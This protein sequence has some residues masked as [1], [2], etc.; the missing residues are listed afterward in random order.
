MLTSQTSAAA[1]RSTNPSPADSGLALAL[2]KASPDCVKVL[3][4]D[5]NLQS[6]ND[7]GQALLEMDDPGLLHGH[8]WPELWREDGGERAT[9]A[10]AMA[11]DGG[12]DRFRGAADTLKGTSK[13]WDVRVSPIFGPDGRPSHILVVSSDITQE[14][15]NEARL[16]DVARRVTEN[17]RTETENLR[18]LL[19]NA[20]SIM[21]VLRGPDHVIELLN[22]AS[23]QLVSFR[24]LLG[25]SVR[26]AFDGPEGQ[27]IA[28]VL[29]GVYRSGEPFLAS[30]APVKL[31]RHKDA[32]P[33][34]AFL[35]LVFQPIRDDQGLITGVFIEGSDIT[36]R[37]RAEHSLAESER[38]LRLAQQVAGIGSLE[39]DVATG[40]VRGS[41]QFWRLWGLEPT[42]SAS[43]TTLEDIVIPEDRAIKSTAET[44][45]AGTATPKVEYRI[46]RPDTGE[47]RWLARHIEFI[48]APDGS[49]R[50]MIGVMQDITER[51]EAEEQR[52]LLTRELEHRMKNT[53]AMVGALATQTLKGNDMPAARTAFGARLAALSSANDILT[54]RSWTS[55]P[56]LEVVEGALAAHQAGED[57]LRLSGTMLRLSAKQALS[58]S[59]G[60]HELATNAAKYGALSNGTGTVDIGWDVVAA[61]P[62]LV[63]LI[64][65]ERGGPPVIPP[66]HRGFGSRL[67]ERVLAADFGGLV[68]IEYDPEGVSCLLEAPL[69]NLPASAEAR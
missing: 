14:R 21:V 47:I 31:Q 4:L 28:E 1:T 32:V 44:R 55:A 40:K 36:D 10:V 63:R 11:R 25:L 34:D 67:I 15:R 42:D 3:D 57:R 20:P 54:L 66:D 46:K 56:I 61:E 60:L 18:R 5:G 17:A 2:L 7:A 27:A 37:V 8:F 6:I 62:P 68:R 49:P 45:A 30:A 23:L 19:H 58:L 26:E 35:N 59:L 12:A 52:A 64:W 13:Y 48:N 51:K 24:A 53:L 39:V 43:I 69:A 16:L 65:R 22:E 38:R 33:E 50:Q 9:A 41:E 29:D